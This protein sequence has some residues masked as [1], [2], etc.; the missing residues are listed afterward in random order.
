MNPGPHY[1][2]N[3]CFF[4]SFS[5][6]CSHR[7]LLIWRLLHSLV[8]FCSCDK[9]FTIYYC[10]IFPLQ[11]TADWLLLLPFNNFAK[12]IHAHLE[13]KLAYQNINRTPSSCSEKA[14]TS[15][16]CSWWKFFRDSLSNHLWYIRQNLWLT[17]ANFCLWD[18]PWHWVRC[19]DKIPLLLDHLDN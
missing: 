8:Y 3:V 5:L 1:P 15:Y 16:K 11:Q 2:G 13:W 10:F 12:C 17:L 9:Q 14:H 6:S 4:R 19:Q 7:V 18:W